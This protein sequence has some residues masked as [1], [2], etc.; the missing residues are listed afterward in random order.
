MKKIIVGI[1]ILVVAIIAIKAIF[2]ALA[3]TW[4]LFWTLLPLAIIIGIVYFVYRQT[5]KATKS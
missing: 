2:V 1:V 3:F 5:K 4:K